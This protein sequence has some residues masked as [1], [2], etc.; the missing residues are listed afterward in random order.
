M[1]RHSSGEL[2]A[3][4]SSSI[5]GQKREIMLE[6]NG[7]H[8]EQTDSI[9]ERY[10]VDL[11]KDRRILRGERE[12][13][14]LRPDLDFRLAHN[15]YLITD[16]EHGKRINK[17]SSFLYTYIDTSCRSRSPSRSP[18]PSKWG[19]GP[20]PVGLLFPGACTRRED[21]TSWTPPD[22]IPENG[23]IDRF[24]NAHYVFNFTNRS[25]WLMTARLIKFEDRNFSHVRRSHVCLKMLS[26]PIEDKFGALSRFFDWW[27]FSGGFSRVFRSAWFFCASQH[28]RPK[29]IVFLR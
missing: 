19:A 2:Y 21:C 24:N 15:G 16:P 3:F 17:L 5:V 8:F 20:S 6:T 22:N 25:E 27:D 12:T 9:S 14:T 13:E 11:Q 29:L 4:V 10:F 7:G 18:Y 23:K 1:H 28:V 26:A